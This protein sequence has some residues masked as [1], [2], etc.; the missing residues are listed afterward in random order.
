MFAQKYEDLNKMLFCNL[1]NKK[2]TGK[3][4]YKLNYDI[5]NYCLITFCEKLLPS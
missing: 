3:W 5:I 4:L 1:E 2:T